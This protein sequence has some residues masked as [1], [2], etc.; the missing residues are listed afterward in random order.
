MIMLM[1]RQVHRHHD[2]VR[3]HHR[4][5]GRREPGGHQPDRAARPDPAREQGVQT[6]IKTGRVRGERGPVHH[7]GYLGDVI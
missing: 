7:A 4:A 2:D 3:R 5:P 6:Q 1:I